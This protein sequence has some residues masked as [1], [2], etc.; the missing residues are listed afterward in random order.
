M[1]LLSILAVSAILFSCNNTKEVLD[2]EPINI[3]KAQLG[4]VTQESD[5]LTINSAVLEGHVL[6]LEVEYS[7]G[8]QDHSYELYGSE[9]VMKSMPPK[10]SIKLVHNSNGDNC[11]E[12]ITE[13]IKFNIQD[14]AAGESSGSEIILLL[15]GTKESISY[16]YP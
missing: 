15:E 11:R 10:R 4:D 1:K 13:T 3:K 16:V 5:P 12:L 7:G 6:T 8:C 9:A 14:L 2:I